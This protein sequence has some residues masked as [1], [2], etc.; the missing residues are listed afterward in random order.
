MGLT[1]ERILTHLKSSTKLFADETT[2]PVLDPGRG[3]TKTGQL[4][5]YA[6][7]DRPGAEP[8]RPQSSTFMRPTGRHRSRSRIS[9]DS[10]AFIRSTATPA[11]ARS[12]KRAT[13]ASP[14]AGPMFDVVF[15]NAPWPKPR[16]SRPKRYSASR[17]YMQLRKTFAAAVQTNAVTSARSDRVP[18][19]P[20]LSTGC[21]QSSRSSARRAS[22][23]RRSDTRSRVGKVSPASSTT[24]KSRSTPIQSNVQS[25]QLPSTVKMHCS[26]AAIL[27][28]FCGFRSSF[29]L[30]CDLGR[31]L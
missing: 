5:A 27:N 10:R 23:P 28:P 22:S 26:P 19:L 8:I 18:F 13:S 1:R 3:R 4:W 30:G 14:S 6:R 25:D 20:N 17:C 9:P 21:A 24:A 29:D 31:W 2:A 11:T 15:M 7:D 16:R 12:P